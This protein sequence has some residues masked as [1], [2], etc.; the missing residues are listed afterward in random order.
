MPG[1][2]GTG[3]RGEGPLTG[4]GAGYCAV[5]RTAGGRMTGFLGLGGRPLRSGRRVFLGLPRWFGAGRRAGRG[6]GRWSW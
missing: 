3:P 5:G 2:D 4:R 1:F 6:R